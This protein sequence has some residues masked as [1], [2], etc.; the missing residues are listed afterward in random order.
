MIQILS[1]DNDLLKMSNA[2]QGN[3]VQNPDLQKITSICGQGNLGENLGDMTQQKYANNYYQYN[4]LTTKVDTIE[5]FDLQYWF[6][7]SSWS[8]VS[9][10]SKTSKS[11]T[12]KKKK[13]KKSIKENIII[14]Y[15]DFLKS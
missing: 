8:K 7:G 2:I 9:K 13:N 10:T 1:N 5:G 15:T 6:N 4:P 3:N 11:K 12:S 14:K